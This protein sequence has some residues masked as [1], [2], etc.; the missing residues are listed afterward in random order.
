MT[1]EIVKFALQVAIAITSAFLAAWLAARR[2]RNDRWWEKKATA[3]S[4]LVESLHN[5]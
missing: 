2:F 5:T 1:A 4:D 3:Y